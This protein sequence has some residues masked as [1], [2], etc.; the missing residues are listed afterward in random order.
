V[1]SAPAEAATLKDVEKVRILAALEEC[2]G[3]KSKAAV[4][5]GISRRTLHRKLNEWGMK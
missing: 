3:N 1:T 4:M 5:L 2:S